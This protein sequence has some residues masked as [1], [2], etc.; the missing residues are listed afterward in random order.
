MQIHELATLSGSPAS[1]HTFPIDTGSVTR[2]VDFDTLQDSIFPTGLARNAIYRGNSL[3]TSV[4][5]AQWSAI[6]AGTFDDMFIGDYWTINSVNWRIAAFDYWYNSGSGTGTATHH[7]VIV[8]DTCLLVG[9]G[10]TTTWMNTSNTTTGGYVGTGFY[11]GTNADGTTNTGKATC[12]SLAEAAFG[13]AHILSHKEYLSNAVTSGYTSA[14][15]F[16]DST[17]ELM[18]EHMVYGSKIYTPAGTGS[19]T[20]L[21]YTLAKTQFPLFAMAPQY[22]IAGSG[23]VR[24][25][26]WLRD[27]VSAVTFA[28]IHATGSASCASAS[29]KDAGIRPTFSICA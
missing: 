5:T 7:V 18:N 24:Q 23:S 9:D 19:V 29:T 8:P 3:G 1:G 26:W 11:S 17:V 12:V 21:S 25:S 22:I 2:K 16:Y 27:V 20:P 15:A 13:S 14:G 10:S 6:S 4:T 28:Y